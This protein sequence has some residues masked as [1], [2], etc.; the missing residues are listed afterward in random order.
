MEKAE[1]LKL[2]RDALLKLHK[3]L[4]DHER[5]IHEGIFGPVSAGQFLKLLLEDEDFAWL[6]KFSTLIVAIDEMFDQKD[7]FSE[8]QVDLWLGKLRNFVH[9][10]DGDEEFNVRYRSALQLNLAA[11]VQH[12]RL[13]ELLP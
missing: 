4:L 7:G 9:L 5:L 12:G 6:R 2:G 3:L 10:E 13:K 11:A 8:A 1:R